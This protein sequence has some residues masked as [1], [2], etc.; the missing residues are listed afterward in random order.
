MSEKSSRPGAG[1]SPQQIVELAIEHADERGLE[2]VSMRKLAAELSVTPM[3]LYW[4]FANR[5]ALVDAMAEH[6]ADNVVYEDD[7]SAPWQER[8]RAVLTATLIAFRAHPWLGPLARHRIVTAPAFL[9]V[10]EV[11]LDTVRAAGYGPTAAVRV[12]EF[13]I[14]SLAALAAGVAGV[15]KAEQRLAS[16]G[17]LEMRRRLLELARADYPRIREAA[18]PLTTP[19]A[20]TAHVKLGIDILVRGIEA[21]A[22]ARRRRR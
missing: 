18:V 21:A 10:L 2:D 11:L 20:P 14:D 7:P 4:H 22:P 15:P 6:A 17:Q 8:L 3:A 1:L 5:D 19:E 16:E 9:G 13:A 12:V